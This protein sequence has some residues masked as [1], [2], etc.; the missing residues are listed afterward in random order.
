MRRTI[1]GCLAALALASFPSVALAHPGHD[2]PGGLWSGL[3]HP[4]TGLDHLLAMI[5]VGLWAAQLGR[6]AVWALPLAF[7]LFMALGA[8]MA[9]RGVWLPGVEVGIAISAVALGAAVLAELRT[10]LWLGVGVVGLLAIFHG[11][12]HGA[13]LPAS[14][15]A[16]LFCLGFVVATA[17]L[18]LAGIGLG[19]ARRWD[20][21]RALVRAA[22]SAVAAAGFWF[23]YAAVG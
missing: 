5:A 7:P 23:V 1:A 16:A 3:T 10:P 6:R 4:V 9:M 14:A 19:L 2:T 13:E 21:G 11:H 15:S 8:W 17:T 18:H 12:A 20:R 22:G